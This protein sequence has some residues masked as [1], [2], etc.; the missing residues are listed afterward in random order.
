[1]NVI[2]IS[3]GVDVVGIEVGMNSIAVPSS[4]IHHGIGLSPGIAACIHQL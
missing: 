4:D 1:M 2:D 3:P